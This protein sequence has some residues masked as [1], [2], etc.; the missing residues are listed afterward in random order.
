MRRN[1]HLSHDAYLGDDEVGERLRRSIAGVSTDVVRELNLLASP[2]AALDVSFYQ[3]PATAEFG[4]EVEWESP[5]IPETGMY[6]VYDAGQQELYE[7]SRVLF[8]DKELVG[9]I[10]KWFQWAYED[11]ESAGEA[12]PNAERRGVDPELLGREDI[13]TADVHSGLEDFEVMVYGVQENWPTVAAVLMGV[14]ESVDDFLNPETE[15]FVAYGGSQG[16]QQRHE[17][18]LDQAERFGRGKPGEIL[19]AK[20]YLTTISLLDE[21]AEVDGVPKEVVRRAQRGD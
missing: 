1:T 6:W 5:S 3:D 20:A 13:P 11:E 8:Q 12:K 7:P 18:A 21:A 19:Q 16:I 14:S 17:W 4:I 15:R 10:L 2:D 9:A